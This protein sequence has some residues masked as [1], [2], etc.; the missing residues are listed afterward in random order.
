M[1]KDFV[2]SA[3]AWK[4]PFYLLVWTSLFCGLEFYAR[5]LCTTNYLYIMLHQQ[6]CPMVFLFNTNLLQSTQAKV[7]PMKVEGGNLTF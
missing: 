5:P 6:Q 3:M 7:S 4:R 2:I 1:K